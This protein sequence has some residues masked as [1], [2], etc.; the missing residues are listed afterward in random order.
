M[1][2]PNP[3]RKAPVIGL[4]GGI[5][6]GKTAVSNHLATLGAH[7]IDADELA[8]QLTRPNGQAM[9]AI[10]RAFGAQAIQSD[11]SMNRDYIRKLVFEQPTQRKTLE[12]ILHP[13]IEHHMREA[14]RQPTHTYHVLVIPLLLEKNTWNHLMDRILVIDCPVSIQEQRVCARNGWP[15]EQVRAVISAQVSR[16]TRLAQADFVLDNSKSTDFLIQQIEALDQKLRKI[17][18]K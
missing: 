16:E 5:G 1:E 8:H 4:T 13:A 10:E 14:L 7:I 2:P 6:S 17:V 9:P 15:I 11:G 3:L 18:P 12:H